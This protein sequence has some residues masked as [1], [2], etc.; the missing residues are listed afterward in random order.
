MDS[1]TGRFLSTDPFPGYLSYPMSQHDYVY[2]GNSPL[3][4]VDP[5]GLQLRSG[6]LPWG[7]IGVGSATGG[8]GPRPS[9]VPPMNPV[10]SAV[11]VVGGICAWIAGTV[12]GEDDADEQGEQDDGTFKNRDQSKG[13]KAEINEAVK[14]LSPGERRAFHEEL[15]QSKKEGGLVDPEDLANIRDYLFPDNPYPEDG[16]LRKKKR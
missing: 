2:V 9:S 4:C 16:W 12:N 13:E 5:S 14:G 10:T 6:P 8:H 11:T 1:G 15:R 3:N 7:P